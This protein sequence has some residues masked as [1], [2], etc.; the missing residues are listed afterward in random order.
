[1]K[2]L[3][4]ITWEQEPNTRPEP[5]LF[6]INTPDTLSARLVKVSAEKTLCW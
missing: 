3:L 6:D 4:Q 2:I 5:Q 1:M